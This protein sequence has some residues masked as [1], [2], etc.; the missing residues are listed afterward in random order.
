MEK[1]GSV[2]GLGASACSHSMTVLFVGCEIDVD[3]LERLEAVVALAWSGRR[4]QG[5]EDSPLLICKI[6]R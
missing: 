2:A 3:E 6:T 1:S 4:D 5:L